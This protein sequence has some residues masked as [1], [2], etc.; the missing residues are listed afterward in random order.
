MATLPALAPLDALEARLGRGTLVEPQKTQ[1]QAALADASELVRAETNQSWV[2]DTGLVTAPAVVITITLQAALRVV[3]NP[4][5]LISETAGPFSR[6]LADDEVGAYL[7][8][9]EIAVLA[10]YRATTTS[11]LWAQ[12][13]TRGEGCQPLGFL[14]DQYGGDP[15][16]WVD[17]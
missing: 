2:A 12:P 7:T 6:R 3:R 1:A 5:G 11:G 15:I 13:T 10:R 4:D 8:A 14:R 16:P 17:R 9:D